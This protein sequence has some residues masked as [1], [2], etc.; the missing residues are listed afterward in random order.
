MERYTDG[1]V[2]IWH[3]QCE[4]MDP[5]WLV[6][7]AQAPAAGVMVCGDVFLANFERLIIYCSW[8]CPLFSGENSSSSNKYLQQDNAPFLQTRTGFMNMTMCSVNIC[9]LSSHR[10]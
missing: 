3:L 1:R 9:D 7:T 2:R 5:I 10:I 4:S 6:S 8:P